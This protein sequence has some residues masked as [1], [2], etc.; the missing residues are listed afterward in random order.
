MSAP[1]LLLP[2]LDNIMGSRSIIAK[3]ATALQTVLA[4]VQVVEEEAAHKVSH[5]RT[6]EPD[7]SYPVAPTYHPS[8]QLLPV[9]VIKGWRW[10]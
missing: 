3:P 9:T 8:H 10:D 1:I 7:K 4:A 5:K 2:L 6:G